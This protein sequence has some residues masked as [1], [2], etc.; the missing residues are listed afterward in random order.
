M[1]L[2]ENETVVRIA[3][4]GDGVTGSG[5]HVA[6]AVPGDIVEAGGT[7][8]AGP[9]RAVPVCDHFEKCGACQLQ[10]LGERILSKFLADRV[11]FAAK[12]QGVAIERIAEAHL[13]PAY[14]RR[15]ATLHFQRVG[16]RILL[17][18]R[19]AG[20]HRIV[21][22]AECHV[23][24]P[25]LFALVAPVRALLEGWPGARSGDVGLALVDQGVDLSIKGAAP[26]GFEA[27]EALL[28]FARE[29]QLARLSVD[30]G[31]GPEPVWEPEPVTVTLGGH[32][33]AYPVGAFL[34][35]TA[36][37]EAALVAA[38]KEW[39][40][41]SKRIAD[42]FA[43]LGTFAF[44][45]ADRREV[46]AYEAARDAVLAGMAAARRLGPGLAFH[47]RDL[48]RNP[49]SAEECSAFDAILLDPPRA[50]AKEQV[51]RIAQSDVG[52]VVYISCNPASWAR[53]AAILTGAGF[54]VEEARPVGQFRWSTHVEL[55]SLLVR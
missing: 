34:Q 4:R 5:R 30:H 8:L 38:A 28:D 54:R 44:A 41:G 45:L 37:G 46:A 29:R 48:F 27:T 50:G 53:D 16:K 40:G 47:H 22:L 15:R 52:R 17:G 1:S 3:A 14:A 2:G 31:F 42:L 6:G 7:V 55:A 9:N 51:E 24:N 10:H 33:V 43:G 21:D 20:S 18:F 13:S 11:R 12:A 35:A 36:D 19:E 25:N 49:L 23:L 32:P 26:E 39:L